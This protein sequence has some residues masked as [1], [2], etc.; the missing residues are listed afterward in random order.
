MDT[1]EAIYESDLADMEKLTHAFDHITQLVLTNFEREVELA[2][3]MGDV[4][5]KIRAQMRMSTMEHAR[6][7]HHSC[8]R[9]IKR[10]K[11]RNNHDER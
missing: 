3:A 9:N 2:Q 7:I 5:G 1:L 10:Q 11:P 4:E 8:Y 6:S